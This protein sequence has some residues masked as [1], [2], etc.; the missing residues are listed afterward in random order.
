MDTRLEFADAVSRNE[1]LAA[2]H[3][4]IQVSCHDGEI[5][6]FVAQELDR[7][8]RHPYCTLSYLAMMEDLAGT[9][10]YVARQNGMPIVILLYRRT[11]SEVTVINDYVALGEEE[12]RRFACHLFDRFEAVRRI[13]FRMLQ[14][15]VA[16]L[17]Y[18][19][20]AVICTED[21]T[22]VLPATVQEYHA[23][24]G[25][26]MRRNIK[27]YTDALLADFPTYRYQHFLEHEI[28][29]QQ[30]REIVALSC[31]RM[32]SKNIVPR[33]N[34]AEIRWIIDL[35]KRCG[36]IGVATIDGRIC[37]GAIGFRMGEDYFMH[38]IAH[39]L[40]YN[41]YSLG[42]LCYF[43][44]ICE[45]IARGGKQFHLL[46]GRYGYK[47]RLLAQRRDLVHLDIYRNRTCLVLCCRSALQKELQG[48][49]H[50]VKQWLLHDVERQEG[51]VCRLL[52]R[53][54]NALRKARRTRGVPVRRR[55]DE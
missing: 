12:I 22:V 47:Y 31:M 40:Q 4:E 14:A 35:A 3:G 13:S 6:A 17:G 39:D 55:L 23:A 51:R 19:R 38:V 7:L 5:P 2:R 15:G 27:R 34:E 1:A 28:G 54:V 53:T 25:R 29:E 46:Q 50:L 18:P 44:T 37:A 36:M 41:D 11:A 10:T 49:I 9:S 48:R 20:H 52:A 32:E 24:V 21:M 26:N 8:Y 16:S 45:G 43:K 33:F 30:I 42:I